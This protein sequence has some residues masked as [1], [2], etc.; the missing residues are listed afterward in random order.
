MAI[1]KNDCLLLLT[2]LQEQGIECNSC[3]TTLMRE[4]KPSIEVLKFINENRPLDLGNFYEKLRKSY[5]NKKSSLYINIMKELED[6]QSVL[7]TLNSYALQVLIFAKDLPEKQMF[8]QFSRLDEVYKCLNYYIT[9]Y[10]LIPCVKLL[11]LIKS[12]IKVLEMLYRD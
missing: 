1:T 8:Y 12:D 3:I 2:E 7:T 10:N 11:Q 4:G 5:N 9:T 6:P